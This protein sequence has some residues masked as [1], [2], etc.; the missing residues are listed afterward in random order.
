MDTC[1]DM[2]VDIRIGMRVPCGLTRVRT[3][4]VRVEKQFESSL[5]FFEIR[6][7]RMIDPTPSAAPRLSKSRGRHV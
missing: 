1:M 3:G 6:F 7:T 5:L 4:D 2:R